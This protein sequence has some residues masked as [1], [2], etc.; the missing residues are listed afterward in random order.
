MKTIAIPKEIFENIF[1]AGGGEK[2]NLN[3][4][5]TGEYQFALDEKEPIAEPNAEIEGGEYIQDSQGIRKAEGKSHETGGMPVKLED[6]TKIV[7]NHLQIGIPLAKYLKESAGLEVKATDTYSKVLDKYTKKIGLQEI[8]DNLEKNIALMEQEKKNDKNT[9]TQK[10]NEQYISKQINNLTKEK[11]PLEKQREG[12]FAML[13]QAQEATKEPQAGQNFKMESGGEI[14]ELAYKHGISQERA[15]E[16]LNLQKFAL[17]GEQDNP[18]KG[19][20][21]VSGER[22]TGYNTNAYQAAERAKQHATGTAFGAVE[23]QKALQELYRNFPDLVYSDDT[24][25]KHIEVDNRGNI[26]FKGDIKLN[27]VQPIIG[28]LQKKMDTR[29]R[30]TAQNIIDNP[31]SYGKEAVTKA[32][33]YLANQ[34]FDEKQLARGFDSKLGQFTSGRYS[35]AMN[36]VTPEDKKFLNDNGVFTLKQLKDSPLRSK[37]SPDS[38]RN[39][40]DTEKQ[41]GTTDADYAINQFDIAQAPGEVTPVEKTKASDLGKRT[42]WGALSLSQRIPN[43]PTLQSPLKFEERYNRKEATHI[44]PTE[45]LTEADRM[46]QAVMNQMSSNLSGSDLAL[47]GIGISA[48]AAANRNKVLSE[49]NRYNA[50]A[51]ERAADY[52]NQIGDREQAAASNNAGKYQ[53]LYMRGIAN[54][55]NDLNNMY[56]RDFEDQ[57]NN[58]KT[59]NTTNWAN[60]MNPQAQ[61]TGYGYA[62]NWKPDLAENQAVKNNQNAGLTPEQVS[63]KE[64]GISITNPAN[65]AQPDNAPYTLEEKEMIRKSRAKV[66]FG[67]RFKKK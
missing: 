17:G 15:H 58:W 43:F 60:A 1:F 23:A 22:G 31:G 40:E 7:S 5:L 13:F 33:D 50:A 36:L 21:T 65:N 3:K 9:D 48:N 24:L 45:Q 67:G 61:N 35:M 2:K 55:E 63:Q 57:V 11:E 25:K 49:T 62:A 19:K 51:D 38:I 37:L 42:Q 34:T 52:N 30:A 16:L 64:R 53:E 12:L 59:V 8:N 10:L 26:K 20:A 56:N 4:A 39:I 14:E 47:A 32:S 27:T 44:S 66:K 54:Y 28:G 46:N 29:M 18:P 6:G 41:I